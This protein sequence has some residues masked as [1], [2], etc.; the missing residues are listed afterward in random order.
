M[1]RGIPV[2]IEKYLT[3]IQ[4][5]LEVGCTLHEACLHAVTPYTTVIDY[6]NK[7]DEVRNK[8]ERMQNV[9]ILKARESLLGGIETSPELALKFLERKKK[10]EFSLRN[11]TDITSNGQALGA[12]INIITPNDNDSIQTNEETI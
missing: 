2:D 7:D 8:I 10:D 1:P 6:V 12:V 4:P 5:Y 9:P 11:E 3:N